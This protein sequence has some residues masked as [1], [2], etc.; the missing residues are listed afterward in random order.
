MTKQVE[1]ELAALRQAVQVPVVSTVNLSGR[2]STVRLRFNNDS[3]VPLSIK[4]RL[5]S[6]SGKLEFTDDP[7]PLVLEPRSSREI[8]F[9]VVAKSNGTSGVTLETFAPNDTPL[10]APVAMVFSVNALG[11]GNVVTVAL[12]SVV[13]L[14]W[15][16][17]TRSVRRKRRLDSAATL[18]AS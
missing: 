8:P 11:L 10:G 1:D 18:P 12:V 4:V 16:Q 13:L 15:L 17:H 5:S 7:A 6:P 2:R 14:W 9:A 3:D